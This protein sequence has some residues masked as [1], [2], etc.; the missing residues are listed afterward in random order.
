MRPFV[1]GTAAFGRCVDQLELVFH[2]N[3]RPVTVRSLAYFLN[4]ARGAALIPQK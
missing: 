1:G 2:L 3:R 4:E